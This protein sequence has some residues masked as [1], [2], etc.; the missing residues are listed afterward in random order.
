MSSF[1]SGRCETIPETW[2][3]SMIILVEIEY[4]NKMY[5][6]TPCLNRQIY[7]KFSFKSSFRQNLVTRKLV[8]CHETMI[9]GILQRFQS[10]LARVA[11]TAFQRLSIIEANSLDWSTIESFLAYQKYPS[12]GQGYFFCSSFFFSLFQQK[13]DRSQTRAVSTCCDCL[14]VTRCKTLITRPCAGLR[15]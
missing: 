15:M 10:L 13:F 6:R 12:T 11:N 4:W 7:P 14:L 9:L 5:P 2:K 1:S 3:R 8:D